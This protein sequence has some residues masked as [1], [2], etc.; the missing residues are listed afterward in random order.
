MFVGQ[1]SR[2]QRKQILNA[3]SN[4]QMHFFLIDFIP[5]GNTRHCS[6]AGLN[7]QMLTQYKKWVSLEFR[8]KRIVRKVLLFYKLF[9]SI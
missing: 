5:W 7:I 3:I 1:Q 2:L 8:T 6:L 9:L 4:L